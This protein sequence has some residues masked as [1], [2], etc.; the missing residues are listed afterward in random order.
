M[1]G[2]TFAPDLPA[3][4][5]VRSR[6]TKGVSTS[7]S[8]IPGE[9]RRMLGKD[10]ISADVSISACSRSSGGRALLRR[11]SRQQSSVHCDGGEV[12]GTIEMGGDIWTG[13]GGTGVPMANGRAVMDGV[14]DD[15]WTLPENW[16]VF[17]TPEGREY[18]FDS[19]RDVVQW[20]RPTG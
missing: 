3:R 8:A 9:E 18:F 16:S 20:E 12:E 13:A 2:C 10:A 5:G 1:S 14:D 7:A 4:R 15:S 6:Q 17:V 19:R 11:S